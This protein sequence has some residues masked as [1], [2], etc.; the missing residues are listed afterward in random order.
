MLGKAQIMTPT[1]IRE[2]AMYADSRD[3]AADWAAGVIRR[4]E[5]I[6][7][8]DLICEVIGD[9]V[10]QDGDRYTELVVVDGAMVSFVGGPV[11][12]KM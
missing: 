7:Y 12:F 8:R 11:E 5:E 9:F 2:L 6:V 1:G 10:D 4:D 3:L